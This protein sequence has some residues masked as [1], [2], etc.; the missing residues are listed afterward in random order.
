MSYTD[1][2]LILP[3]NIRAIIEERT[4]D[5]KKVDEEL[6]VTHSGDTGGIHPTMF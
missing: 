1:K 6:V 3:E 2:T 4:E 5:I